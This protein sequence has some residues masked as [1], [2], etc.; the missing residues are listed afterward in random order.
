MCYRL[1][2]AQELKERLRHG[3]LT[4]STGTQTKASSGVLGK[5]SSG[6]LVVG[7]GAGGSSPAA[8][9]RLRP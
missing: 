6:T 3:G 1:G 9:A 5:S 8:A 4:T 7:S 2:R